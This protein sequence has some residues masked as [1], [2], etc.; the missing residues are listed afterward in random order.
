M[1]GR[2]QAVTNNVPH[3]PSRILSAEEK[4]FLR[5]VQRTPH[6]DTICMEAVGQVLTIIAKIF[7]KDAKAKFDEFKKPITTSVVGSSEQFLRAAYLPFFAKNHEYKEQCEKIKVLENR[8]KKCQSAYLQEITQL[9][10]QARKLAKPMKG[11]EIAEVDFDDDREFFDA[12]SF[13]DDETKVLIKQIVAEKV[14]TGILRALRGKMVP[15][16]GFFGQ[17]GQ[18]GGGM[19]G[20]DD[21]EK[22][23]K[24]LEEKLKQRDEEIAAQKEKIGDLLTENIEMKERLE[25]IPELHERIASLESDLAQVMQERDELEEAKALIE[26]EYF[27][28]REEW[29]VE[30]KLLTDEIRELE[31]RV[32]ELEEKSATALA[33]LAQAKVAAEQAEAKM[34][35]MEENFERERK[36]FRRQL[37]LAEEKYKMQIKSLEEDVERLEKKTA[38]LEKENETLK[39]KLAAA[40]AQIEKLKL[41]IEELKEALAAAK[42]D[43]ELLEG[44]NKRLQK[45]L[46]KLEKKFVKLS[47]ALEQM[48]AAGQGIP[49]LGDEMAKIME[50]VNLNDNGPKSVFERLYSDALSR[51]KRLEQMRLQM[52]DTQREALIKV[53]EN[54]SKRTEL[55]SA[56]ELF[57]PVTVSLMKEK[58]PKKKKLPNPNVDDHYPEHHGHIS[59]G[60]GRSTMYPSDG[61]KTPG[62]ELWAYSYNERSLSPNSQRHRSRSQSPERNRTLSPRMAEGKR[63][64]PNFKN[65]GKPLPPLVPNP[66]PSL[67][68]VLGRC[69]SYP[70]LDAHGMTGMRNRSKPTPHR[71]G[72]ASH[73]WQEV[74][75]GQSVFSQAHH[76]DPHPFAKKKIIKGEKM[77]GEAWMTVDANRRAKDRS[78][79]TVVLQKDDR[80]YQDPNQ[81]YNTQLG[82]SD[83]IQQLGS[84]SIPFIKTE[85][86]WG[87]DI[88]KKDLRIPSP[89]LLKLDKKV[90]ELQSNPN[91]VFH[92][93]HQNRKTAPSTFSGKS[94]QH[95]APPNSTLVSPP[96]S[97][98][99][100]R[101][102]HLPPQMVMEHRSPSVL[103]PRSLS[104]GPGRSTSPIIYRMVSPPPTW[105]Q[106][107]QPPEFLVSGHASQRDSRKTSKDRP[108]KSGN[109]PKKE[110][111]ERESK[112]EDILYEKIETEPEAL[113]KPRN[114]DEKL[115]ESVD[116]LLDADRAT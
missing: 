17:P 67:G 33:E 27:A 29:E 78:P 9:K 83:S 66:Y 31:E 2:R 22:K 35:E 41:K 90:L 64:P 11:D 16:I 28:A 14:K 21:D 103:S 82:H 38:R 3:S 54:R 20:G 58:K 115:R 6:Y 24:E 44:E 89:N 81:E 7:G 61:E 50:G 45:D 13:F 112:D 88:S 107:P 79:E 72:A 19:M 77:V 114:A 71:N 95:S 51:W 12:V 70:A 18:G 47:S 93:E 84:G 100:G 10:N 30:K 15:G 37:E 108:P 57:Q 46:V 101:A 40:N 36:E 86:M 69:Q 60:S 113:T 73:A 111:I 110:P 25:I 76:Q 74:G 55:E 39:E 49:G 34:Q 94:G 8:I 102:S 97:G 53:L 59:G 1:A 48:N 26:Q 62:S 52:L 104:L 96:D 4:L 92:R 87:A 68:N 98:G 116:A 56:F 75:N 43:T 65:S 80:R 42:S 23:M 85:P 5:E 32:Q 106:V 109:V 105:K 91:L 63:L 99:R